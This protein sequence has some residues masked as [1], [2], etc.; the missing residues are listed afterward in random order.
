MRPYQHPMFIFLL[1]ALV[2]YLLWVLLYDLW[3]SPQGLLDN[4]VIQNS[5]YFTGLLL[6]LLG[7]EFESVGRLVGLPNVS[8]LWIGNSCNAV[9][10]FALFTAF[11]IAYPG[12]VIKKL[13]FIPLGI[14]II[15]FLNALRI[16]ALVLLQ[17]HAPGTLD[18]NHTYTFTI[19]VYTAI[20]AGWMYWARLSVK[21]SA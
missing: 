4:W 16:A 21:Y 10:L 2:L 6:G 5:I 11:I 3:L 7:Y 9:P 17:L 15:H 18:F 20:F 14:V 12:P 1:K 13:L 19:L 8:G